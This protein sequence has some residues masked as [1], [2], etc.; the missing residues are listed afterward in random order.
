M[1]RVAR[2][3]CPPLAPYLIDEVAATRTYVRPLPKQP[4]DTALGFPVWTD[5]PSLLRSHDDTLSDV[6]VFVQV[7]RRVLHQA[8]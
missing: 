2:K 8:R 4:N 5:S 7:P 1:V 3:A 6:D